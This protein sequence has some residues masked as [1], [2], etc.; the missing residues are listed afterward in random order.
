MQHDLYDIGDRQTM[1]TKGA[2]RL[3]SLLLNTREEDYVKLLMYC[4]HIRTAVASK[5]FHETLAIVDEP[6]SDCGV[7]FY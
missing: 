1:E 5:I 6:Q 4:R 7:L 2:R 3:W